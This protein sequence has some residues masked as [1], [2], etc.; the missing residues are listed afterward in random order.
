MHMAV[1]AKLPLDDE[2]DD[3][4]HSAA[5]AGVTSPLPV[6]LAAGVGSPRMGG[7]ILLPSSTAWLTLLALPLLVWLTATVTG[8]MHFR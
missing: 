1:P 3:S 7:G 2:G 5:P 8:I 6:A 4:K